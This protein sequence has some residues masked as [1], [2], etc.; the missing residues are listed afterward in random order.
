MY[1][2]GVLI[3]SPFPNLT[4]KQCQTLLE[5]K[6]L[7]GSHTQYGSSGVAILLAF[8]PYHMLYFHFFFFFFGFGDF[9]LTFSLA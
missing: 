3:H 6:F 2:L 8:A 1:D 4:P 5:P 7:S 9:E